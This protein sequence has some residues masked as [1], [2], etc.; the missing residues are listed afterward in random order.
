MQLTVFSVNKCSYILL[1]S[2]F[3]YV[4]NTQQLHCVSIVTFITYVLL[5]ITLR[6]SD[7]LHIFTTCIY[8]LCKRCVYHGDIGLKSGGAKKRRPQGE[9]RA[10]CRVHVGIA[11]TND[12]SR[13]LMRGI[14]ITRLYQSLVLRHYSYSDINY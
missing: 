2:P 9:C 13:P 6:N 12:A 4:G 10:G 7:F 8:S 14:P 5:R 3:A 11:E 1:L